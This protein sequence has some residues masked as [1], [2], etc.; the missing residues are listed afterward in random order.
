MVAHSSSSG[1]PV[2]VADLHEKINSI[3]G[4]ITSARE[5]VTPLNPDTILVEISEIKKPCP[6]IIQNP[7][8]AEGACDK[9]LETI[10]RNVKVQDVYVALDKF[11]RWI[12]SIVDVVGRLDQSTSL[13]GKP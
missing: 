1:G 8:I 2:T 12:Q 7:H 10:E 4:A 13:P 3:K 11:E 5:L 9:P 6:M